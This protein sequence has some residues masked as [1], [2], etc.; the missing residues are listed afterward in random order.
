M[1]ITKAL[2]DDTD[3][4]KKNIYMK[5][6][7]FSAL[8]LM[9]MA[10]V[11]TVLPGC[12]PENTDPSIT[13][14]NLKVN[15][16]EVRFTLT[17]VNSVRY[18]YS[19]SIK[20]ENAPMNLIGNN[21]V[22]DVFLEN[23]EKG[24]T[25]E[26]KAVAYGKENVKSELSSETFIAQDGGGAI[27]ERKSLAIK[28]TGT[29]CNNCPL[30]TA[31]LKQ[32]S[33]ESPG[34]FVT[35]GTHIDQG[36]ERPDKFA[37]PAGHELYSIYG[38]GGVPMTLIDYRDACSSSVPILKSAMKKS[39][40]DYFTSSSLSITSKIEGGKAIIEVKAKFSETAD[41]KI[42]CAITE[43]N[44]VENNTLGS[45][46]GI[47]NNVLRTF[48]TDILGDDLGEMEAGTEITKNYTYDVSKWNSEN[49]KVVAFIIKNHG[50]NENYVNN[51]NES[52]INGSVDFN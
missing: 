33:D 10:F 5:K 19:V 45:R 50:G 14:T 47:Y 2:N 35:I 28:F 23:L 13:I 51:A 41:Y 29:W 24:A 16:T 25:Y 1:L 8:A 40:N 26:I 49:L 20:G 6:M 48:L 37:I 46:D 39:I 44:L 9:S 12:T 30:M 32:I 21:E 7:L 22:K 43:D 4:L 52:K 11:G 31:A 42:A 36:V 15:S 3:Y 17:P 34:T 18:E 27:Y 38:T